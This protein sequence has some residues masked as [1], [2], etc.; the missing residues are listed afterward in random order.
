MANDQVL[1][2]DI[3]AQPPGFQPRP[4]LLAQ[5][6]RASQGPP[7][8]LTGTWGVG[9]TQLAAAYARARLAA[10]WRLIA[11]VNAGDSQSLLA[12]MAAVAAAQGC[13]TAVPAGHS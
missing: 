2:G 11:W 12:G 8:V 1:V 9:K 6:N 10:G 4:V 7:V 5:L 3:P 13:R